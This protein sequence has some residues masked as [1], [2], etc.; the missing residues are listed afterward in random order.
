[1]SRAA[2]VS[3]TRPV[4]SSIDSVSRLRNPAFAGAA[5]R[6]RGVA[7]RLHTPVCA[8]LAPCAPGASPP[9]V[10][11]GLRRRDTR[12]RRRV[13]LL[14]QVAVILG[15]SRLMRRPFAR[16]G[17][18]P[19]I[20]EMVAGLMLGPSCFG[21]L[22]PSWS[23]AVFPP[24]TLA[25]LN[26]LS[27][28]GLVLFM[29]LV[30]S[31][32]R[33]RQLYANRSV[34]VAVGGVSIAVP[35]VMGALVAA[36]MHHD[37][38]PAGVGVLPFALFMGAAMSMTAFP[39][40][41]RILADHRLLTTDIGVIAITCAAFDD[42][43]GWLL[44][45]AVTAL[46][47]DG[48]LLGQVGQFALV[49]GYLAI[50]I[51]VARLRPSQPCRP[52]GS[53]VRRLVRRSRA[54][55]ASAAGVRTDDGSAWRPRTVRRLRCRSRPSADRPARIESGGSY[56]AARRHAAPAALLRRCRPADGIPADRQHVRRSSTRRSSS[57]WPSS[58]K[59]GPP[60]WRRA[61]MGVGWRDAAALGALLNTRGLVEL[62]ILSIGLDIG[63]LSPLAYSNHGDDGARHDADDVTAAHPADEGRR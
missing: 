12:R 55:P 34:A 46:V 47:R 20:G 60:P 35:F 18:P 3:P 37:T 8:L 19:V 26:A 22:L 11:T 5:S 42:V 28:V 41:A 16:L 33:P 31:R 50:M 61:L 51:G 62:V 2:P 15:L 59:A 57:R 38:A 25:P 13:I 39:V 48:R 43:I 7:R 36:V 49:G 9:S 27:Q 1:M 6:V 17:Q 54:A 21:W 29:F 14:L 30:G 58:P 53:G 4:G 10:L 23:A 63:V 40:L 52:E 32:V 45:A 24:D 44:V 56:R